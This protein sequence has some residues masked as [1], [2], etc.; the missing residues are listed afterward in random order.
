MAEFD[1]TAEITAVLKE[2]TGDVMDKVDK[3]VRTCGNGMRKEIQATSPKRTGTYS[4]DWRLKSST[5]WRGNS[6][7][8]V[9]NEDHYQLTHLLE[10]R[11]KK[12]TRV[13]KVQAK[14]KIWAAKRYN[15]YVE[16]QPH[17]GPAEKKWN[18][19]FEQ[20]CEEACRGK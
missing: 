3:A 11:H 6:S 4:K 15:G 13:V 7:A 19:K 18:Q 12:R 1:L 5:E 14:G 10:K 9:Y 20:M 17:I 8:L 16:P 2:Y